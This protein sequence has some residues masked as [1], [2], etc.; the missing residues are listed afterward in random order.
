MKTKTLAINNMAHR[1]AAIT[2]VLLSV[3]ASLIKAT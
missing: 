1:V 3:A 2:I